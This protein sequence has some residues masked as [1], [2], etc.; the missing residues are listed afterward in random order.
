MNEISLYSEEGKKINPQIRKM[1]N[2]IARKHGYGKA[3]KIRFSTNKRDIFP[4][5][6]R[7]NS[8]GYF[9]TTKNGDRIQ[10][11]IAYAKKGFSNMFYTSARCMI[12]LPKFM[13]SSL[14]A[15]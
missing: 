8:R 2:I 4:K 1:C 7:N 5:I 14:F 10:Y 12:I 15:N 13:E 11:P 6:D 3:T 9:W